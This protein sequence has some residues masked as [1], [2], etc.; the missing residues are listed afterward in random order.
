MCFPIPDFVFYLDCM[1]DICMERVA[2]RGYTLATFEKIELLNK[3]RNN[4]LGMSYSNMTVIDGSKSIGKI[5]KVIKKEVM[6]K[7]KKG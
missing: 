6:R 5:A 7:L 1:P 3:I 4:Y 2:D